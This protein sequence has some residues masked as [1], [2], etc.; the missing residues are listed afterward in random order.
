MLYEPLPS[1]S[2][3]IIHSFIHFIMPNYCANSF[4]ITGPKKDRD[5]LVASVDSDETV[6][7]FGKIRP[8][9]RA[10]REASA[11]NADMIR[12]LG[13]MLGAKDQFMCNVFAH[14]AANTEVQ[15]WGTKWG[16]CDAEL[17]H[18]DECKRVGCPMFSV[19]VVVCT[20]FPVGLL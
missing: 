5:A 18:G 13:A 14:V 11:A 3:L 7:D 2:A 8:I 17:K 12:S 4:V 10:K 1:D 6:L 19:C 20:C 15:V 9:D 16:A